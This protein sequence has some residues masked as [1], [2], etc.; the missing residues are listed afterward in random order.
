MSAKAIVGTRET[1]LAPEFAG[2]TWVRLQY[3]LGLQRLGIEW[4]WVD[5][6][7]VGSKRRRSLEY[8]LH[9]FHRTATE[10]GLGDRYC[11]VQNKGERYFGMSEARFRSLVDDADVVINVS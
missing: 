9:R 3:L 1:S 10:F 4:F 7:Y 11:V 8:L 2:S 5:H 6:I